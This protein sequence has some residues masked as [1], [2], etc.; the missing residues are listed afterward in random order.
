MGDGSVVTAKV[1]L[2]W[3]LECYGLEK[4]EALA[5]GK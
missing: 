1:G 4:Y 3:F 5:K 2:D